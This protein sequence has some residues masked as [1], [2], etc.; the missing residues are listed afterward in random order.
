MRGSCG[1]TASRPLSA[2]CSTAGTSGRHVSSLG[3]CKRNPSHARKDPVNPTGTGNS[4]GTERGPSIIQPRH[5]HRR[6]AT[7][8]P[9][10]GGRTTPGTLTKSRG[11]QPDQRFTRRLLSVIRDPGAALSKVLCRE[12]KAPSLEHLRR[13]LPPE[14]VA[15]LRVAM[16][17]VVGLRHLV[18]PD[19]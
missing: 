10:L 19:S 4:K 8:C 17:F 3:T 16:H 5:S 12:T 2:S 18:C 6:S 13:T 9:G 1:A 14:D 7:S 15:I 11:A